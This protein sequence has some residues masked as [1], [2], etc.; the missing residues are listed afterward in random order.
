MNS[1]AGFMPFVSYRLNLIHLKGPAQ[2]I[3]QSPGVTGTLPVTAQ[4]KIFT[5]TILNSEFHWEIVLK[6]A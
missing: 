6:P 2:N 3:A 5:A 4:H 1:L